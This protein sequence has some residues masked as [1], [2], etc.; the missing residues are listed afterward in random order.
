MDYLRRVMGI[1]LFLFLLC[2]IIAL[3]ADNQNSPSLE[4]YIEHKT[5]T[6]KDSSQ[7]LP[8]FNLGPQSI[9]KLPEIKTLDQPII[10]WKKAVCTRRYSKKN[11]HPTLNLFCD[12]FISFL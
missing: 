9:F 6:K 2:N 5:T 3:H 4:P 11:Q 10:P 8:I 12:I 7:N 1:E